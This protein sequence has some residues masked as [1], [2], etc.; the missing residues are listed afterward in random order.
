MN[1]SLSE[2]PYP[3][4]IAHRG[5]GKQAPE[6]TLSAMRLGAKHGF[7]M[8]EFDVKLSQDGAAILLHDDTI[9]RTSNAQG[10]ASSYTL[11]ELLNFDFLA[12]QPLHGRTHCHLGHN[13]CLYYC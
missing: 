9:D 12:K 5:A 2:W 11:A 7:K 13:S 10:L 8:V 3:S 4:L 6:N 1:P